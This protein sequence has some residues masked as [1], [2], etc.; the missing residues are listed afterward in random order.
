MA[1]ATEY[2]PLAMQEPESPIEPPP[3]PAP[4]ERP[5]ADEQPASVYAYEPPPAPAP[6][7]ALPPVESTPAPAPTPAPPPV[8]ASPGGTPRPAPKEGAPID[9]LAIT[10]AKGAIKKYGPWIALIV[11]IIVALIVWAIVS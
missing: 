9:L 10:G 5:P 2:H 3:P 1:D 11:V 8:V 4:V 7:P 6:A